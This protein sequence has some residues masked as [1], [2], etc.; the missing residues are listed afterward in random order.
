[1]REEGSC[2]NNSLIPTSCIEVYWSEHVKSFVKLLANTS[3]S[4][5]DAFVMVKTHSFVTPLKEGGNWFRSNA[6]ISY[7][8]VS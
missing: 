2:S 4:S 5:V 7:S 3:L 6:N 8:A 1:M